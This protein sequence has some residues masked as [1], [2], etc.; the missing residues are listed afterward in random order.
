MEKK[1]IRLYVAVLGKWQSKDAEGP[2]SGLAKTTHFV[3][4]ERTVGAFC[5]TRRDNFTSGFGELCPM[6]VQLCQW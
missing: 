6:A 3:V 5:T 2:V 4:S 1:K